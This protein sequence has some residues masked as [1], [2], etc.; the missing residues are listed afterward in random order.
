[1]GGD[2]M[3]IYEQ[4]SSVAEKPFTSRKEEKASGVR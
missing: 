2:M 4:G 3:G 1:M